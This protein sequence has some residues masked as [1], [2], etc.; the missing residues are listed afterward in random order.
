[1]AGGGAATTSASGTVTVG[2]IP[3]PRPAHAGRP[4]D[5]G[6]PPAYRSGPLTLRLR[7]RPRTV[8][9]RIV[10]LLMVPVVSLLA[11]WGFATVT[12]A[13]Q[14]DS[15]MRLKH[16][17]QMLLQPIDATVSAVQAERV[18][19]L[20]YLAAPSQARKDAYDARSKATD[21]TVASMGQNIARGEPDAVG[22]AGALPARLD[23]L[24][25]ATGSLRQLRTRIEGRQIGWSDAADAYAGVVDSGFGVVGSLTGGQNSAVASD[26]RVL[27]ELSQAREMLA[28]EDAA[29]QA[30]QAAGR[31]TPEQY[32]EFTG[33]RYAR[34]TLDA[35]A[36][37]DLRPADL[38]AYQQVTGG[39]QARSLAQMEEAVRA[40][41]GGFK[42]VG[43]AGSAWAPT[44][45]AVQRQLDTVLAA[46]GTDAGANSDPYSLGVMSR[47]GAAVLFGL[48]AVLLSLLISVR[49]GRGL[50]VELV[51]LRNSAL[52]LARR[53]L[54]AAM[55]RLRAGEEI[56]IEAEAPVVEAGD[57]EIGQVGEALNS[58]QRA[59]LTAAVERAEVLS[60]VSGVFVNLARRSQVLVHRQL[61]LLDAMERRTED[62][63]ELEDLF[64]LDHLTTRMRRHAEGLI[65]LSGAAPGRAWRKPVP[66]LDVVRS[67]VAEVEDYSRVDVRRLPGV[68]VVGGAV[69]DLTHLLAELVENAT[70]FSPP[71]TK[72][73][74][75][76]EQVGAG[77]AVE[78]EDRGLG[79]GKEAVAEANRRI[80]D[81]QQADLF[82]SDR[83]GLF[84]VS[85]LARRH[86]VRVSLRPS[87]Y[88]GTTAVVLLPSALLE[89]GR[90]RRRAPLDAELDL[91]PV[92][93]SGS[94]SGAAPGAADPA[95]PA[96]P[97]APHRDADALPGPYAQD[98]PPA[99]GREVPPSGASGAFPRQAGSHGPAAAPVAGDP[100]SAPLGVPGAAAS[101]AHGSEGP[102]QERTSGR[103]LPFGRRG[104]AAVPS[105]AGAHGGATGP[106]APAAATDR[107]TR[108]AVLGGADG[109]YDAVGAG[110]HS[111]TGDAG[112]GGRVPFTA[113][114]APAASTPF[115]R[116]AIT[117]GR[118]DG[119]A[120]PEQTTAQAGGP[121]AP[122][123][124]GRPV[125]SP[126]SGHAGD[127]PD[128]ATTEAGSPVA[129][130]P[131]GRPVVT[132]NSRGGERGDG[133]AGDAGDDGGADASPVA[134]AGTDADDVAEDDSG[135]EL[136]VRRAGASA[137][138]RR[139]ASMSGTRSRRTPQPAL[140]EPTAAGPGGAGADSPAQAQGSRNQPDA[141]TSL[142]GPA[143]ATPS[144]APDG[145]HSAPDG[146]ELPR[147]VRQASLAVQLRETPPPEQAGGARAAA[148]ATERTPEQARATMSA[149][150]D[151]WNRGRDGGHGL[152]SPRPEGGAGRTRHPRLQQDPHDAPPHEDFEDFERSAADGRDDESHR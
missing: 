95:G 125:V 44:A 113:P 22:L 129:P 150:R 128:R 3:R 132:P 142:S 107:G 39:Q 136:P 2:V 140:G 41:G 82:D 36:A 58:V 144:P 89:T 138:G 78:I 87:A 99:F 8:R 6:R 65:I 124:F 90:Q 28:R 86:G 51:D 26:A 131:F 46:A 121:V 40:S 9:A 97:A 70:A 117:S 59:A 49:I 76:G 31:M 53:R 16:V 92:Q 80:A 34:A 141:P 21:A 4:A 15:L 23:A 24:N 5:E 69:A 101:A 122:L 105:G 149:L 115:G 98:P 68:S 42:A 71:H 33:A 88:G 133:D 35:S 54:P 19:A 139:S 73:L 84:V 103:R 118:G 75:T 126:G 104:A 67:A 134:T 37:P 13:Q 14:I 137:A 135:A 63:G 74:V 102:A 18:A 96:G 30:C 20:S 106:V 116:P 145:A 66:L 119:A 1:V 10:S 152:A 143:S 79:M 108:P 52:E 57:D 81:A 72:V 48:A 45:S 27:L 100:A 55:R 148:E 127:E 50:V 64:R 61:T 109:A 56:D 11:L 151:G 47:N 110:A 29:V 32:Q 91:P 146:D 60:G 17:D 7:F 114:S 123:P 111:G 112:F 77:Y 12:T 93:S 43:A 62:P 94:A 130:L 120:S 25:S 83:L 85:R 147:R 38:A